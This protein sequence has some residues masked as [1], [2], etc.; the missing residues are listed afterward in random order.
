MQHEAALAD[1]E[2]LTA[3][4]L[5]HVVPGE[6]FAEDVVGLSSATTAQ[7]EDIAVNGTVLNGSVNITATDIQAC[8][9]VVHVIDA[10]LLPKKSS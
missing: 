7:G 4:L 2:L 8:N 3:V 10:V 9:G 5:Y 1:T 6:V